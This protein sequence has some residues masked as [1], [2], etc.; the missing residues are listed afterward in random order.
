[1]SPLDGWKGWEILFCPVCKYAVEKC[2]VTQNWQYCPYCE[3]KG[4][5]SRLVDRFVVHY[6]ESKVLK[7]KADWTR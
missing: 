3:R 6:P 4:R 2:R 5:E 1:M 7:P